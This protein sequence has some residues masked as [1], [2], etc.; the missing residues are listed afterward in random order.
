MLVKRFKVLLAIALMAGV[1]G[2]SEMGDTANDVA[3]QAKAGVDSA[4]DTA[5]DKADEV[6][7]DAAKETVDGAIDQG[8]DMAKEGIDKAAEAAGG[9]E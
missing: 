1:W 7:P 8:G 5:K 3:D 2:C 4:T 9:G 6:V